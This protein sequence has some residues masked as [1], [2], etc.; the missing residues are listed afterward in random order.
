[1]GFTIKYMQKKN[2]YLK[3]YHL[4]KW[5]NTCLNLRFKSKFRL[6]SCAQIPAAKFFR[7][8]FSLKIIFNFKGAYWIIQ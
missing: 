1:M 8:T 4:M 7:K 3:V 2:V 6:I 5:V